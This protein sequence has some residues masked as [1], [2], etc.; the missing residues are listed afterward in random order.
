MDTMLFKMKKAGEIVRVKRATYALPQDA[1]KIG[2]KERID[3]Q[4][5]ENNALNGNLSNLAD[6]TAP[7]NAPPNDAIDLS[8]PAFLRRTPATPR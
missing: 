5:S 6:L 8:I 2:Q 7:A 3:A 1:G 4:A